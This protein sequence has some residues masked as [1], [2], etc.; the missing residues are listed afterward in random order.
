MTNRQIYGIWTLTYCH[1]DST[2]S[3]NEER[4]RDF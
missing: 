2:E 4:I 3:Y 1:E